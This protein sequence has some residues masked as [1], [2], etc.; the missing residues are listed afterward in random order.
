MPSKIQ[1]TSLTEQEQKEVKGLPRPQIVE[2]KWPTKQIS[3]ADARDAFK[4]WQ[5]KVPEPKLPENP[6]IK[7]EAVELTK[8]T[9]SRLVAVLNSEEAHVEA[10]RQK[11]D[12]TT[13]VS[14]IYSAFLAHKYMETQGRID[15]AAKTAETQR[16]NVVKS[17]QEAFAAGGLR[18]VTEPQL[19]RYAKQI[20]AYP[21]ALN[22][23]TK[24]ANGA[25]AVEGQPEGKSAGG[26][27]KIIP[28]TAK[29]INL[30]PILNNIPYL[31]AGP[32]V[33][34][35]FTKHLSGS[36]SF[37]I[38]FHAP[39]FP[40][41]WKTCWYEIPIGSLAYNLDVNVGYKVNCCGASVWGHVVAQACAS[42]LGHTACATIQGDITGVLGVSK[43]PGSGASC[44]YGLGVIASL[45]ATF[46][47]YTL[48]SASATFGYT[49]NGPCPPKSLNC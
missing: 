9:L 42:A 39:C 15:P 32:L 34:G 25:R 33:Q 45:Q 23:I 21:D 49:I 3:A 48:F 38:A 36:V 31:C 14:T 28:A 30:P 11:F 4:R 24:M 29:F 1:L 18:D 37:T 20:A 10:I 26:V 44:N 47:G 35:V 8:A 2:A 7:I 19:A 43:T 40:K 16:A 41:I 46:A 13:L 5:E 12:A 22:A 6:P 17:F 27:A